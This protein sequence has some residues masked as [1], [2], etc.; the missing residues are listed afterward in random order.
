M[1]RRTPQGVER[2]D[3]I[4]GT[5]S[6]LTRS[7]TR[8]PC[9]FPPRAQMA[10]VVGN[11]SLRPPPASAPVGK[12]ETVWLY[13]DAI[14]HF[15]NLLGVSSR[16]MYPHLPPA[17]SSGRP[18][19]DA[20]YSFTPSSP[21]RHRESLGHLAEAALGLFCSDL[22]LADRSEEVE[23]IVRI[24]LFDLVHGHPRCLANRFEEKVQLLGQRLFFL[25]LAPELL[26]RLLD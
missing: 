6:A 2:F 4:L 13:I 17:F 26:Y 16:S 1:A 5:R 23:E 10:C 20:H 18:G 19:R 12:R 7:G 14:S 3:Q 8:E 25:G 11:Q 22:R 15:F 21:P 9:A 24:H